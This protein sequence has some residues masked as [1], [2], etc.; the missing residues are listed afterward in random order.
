MWLVSL[1]DRP[2]SHSLSWEESVSMHG[3]LGC[4]IYALIQPHLPTAR[5]VPQMFQVCTGYQRGCMFMGLCGLCILCT[6]TIEFCWFA[7]IFLTVFLYSWVHQLDLVSSLISKWFSRRVPSPF[8]R[9]DV[10]SLPL[11]SKLLL[12]SIRIGSLNAEW[13]S[14][15]F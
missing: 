12:P 4:R 6:E 13:P 10:V 7:S 15:Y 1:C 9:M 3:W 14:Y 2:W 11:P 5:L 8:L